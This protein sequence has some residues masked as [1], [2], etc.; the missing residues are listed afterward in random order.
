VSQ[1]D[2]AALQTT[3][4]RPQ[5]AP[6]RRRVHPL[7][8]AHLPG[9]V[10]IAY[11]GGDGGRDALA[12]GE[13]VAAIA[14]G[15]MLVAHVEGEAHRRPEGDVER[16]VRRQ[17]GDR[18]FQMISAP[19][20]AVAD[21]LQSLAEATGAD[22]MVLGSTHLRGLRRLFPWSVG[23]RVLSRVPC[24]VGVAPQGYS[25]L[26][27]AELKVVGAGYDGSREAGEALRVA[28][29]LASAGG[30]VLRIITVAEPPHARLFGLRLEEVR[31]MLQEGFLG[32][33]H[34]RWMRDHLDEALMKALW[35]IAIDG[36]LVEGPAYASLRR[37]AERGLDLL[38]LG[39]RGGYGAA[40]RVMPG[41]V[42]TAAIREAACPTI[43]V[44]RP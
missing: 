37:E 15:E 10:L 16:A 43:V 14:G 31:S 5:A 21:G 20:D 34:R 42:A 12:M 26:E 41:S 35:E 7:T 8:L 13:R 44:P 22:L 40:R 18:T 29:A 38:V 4:P 9:L 2:P 17:L 1:S 39:S 3:V 36:R 27:A 24:A 32:T 33:R 19:S 23:E 30:G 11:D 28:T 25:R 6:R